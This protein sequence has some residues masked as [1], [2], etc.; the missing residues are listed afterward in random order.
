METAAPGCWGRRFC[1][2]HLCDVNSP[3]ATPALPLRRLRVEGFKSIASLDL[4]LRPLNVLIGANGA[5]KSNLI[6]VFRFVREI[7]EQRLQAYVARQGGA[8]RVLHY[9]RRRT[10]WIELS[11]FFGEYKY[12]V[13]IGSSDYDQF[14]LSGETLSTDVFGFD[15]NT[16]PYE[17]R[18]TGGLESNIARDARQFLLS[19]R[20]VKVLQ[21]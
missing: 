18:V 17:H 2:Y 20:I 12:T 1:F 3:V 6:E 21:N 4:E 9:G 15:E 10:D 7:I 14:Y 8:E 16:F 5:G 13:L 11:F 19:A